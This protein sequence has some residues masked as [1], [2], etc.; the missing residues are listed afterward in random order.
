LPLGHSGSSSTF[1]RLPLKRFPVISPVLSP[2]P[3]S[4]FNNPSPR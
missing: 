4:H 2:T 1:L 3:L